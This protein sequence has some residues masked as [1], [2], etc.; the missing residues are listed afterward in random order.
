[1]MRNSGFLVLSTLLASLSGQT[2][3]AEDAAPIDIRSTGYLMIDG[4]YVRETEDNDLR[5]WE[6]EPFGTFVGGLRLYAQPS[7]KFSMT[8]NPELKSMNVFPIRPGIQQGEAVQKTKYDIYLEEAKGTWRFGDPV[9]PRAMLDFG[10]IIYVDNP[11]TKVL[12]NYLFRSMV[13]PGILFTKMDNTAAY[14]FG[15]HGGLDFL[16]GR[17]KNHAFLLSEVQH[18]PFFDLSLG[19][20]GSYAFGNFM[21]IGAGFKAN[22]LVPIRPSRTTPENFAYADNTYKTVP[23]QTGTV[24]T[25]DK[26]RPF[27]VINIVPR[28]TDSAQVTILDSAGATTDSTVLRRTGN[29]IAGIATTGPIGDKIM[30]TMTQSGRFGELYPELNGTNLRYSFSGLLV[31]GRIS[32]NPMAVFGEVNPLGRDALKIY[33]EAAVLGWKNYPGFYENRSERTPIMLGV[34][35]PTFNFVDYVSVEL[36]QYKSKELP[37]YD[38]RSFNNVPQPGNHKGEVETRW[39]ADRRAKD[40]LKWILAAKK[41]FRGW[42]LAAQVGTDHTKLVDNTDQALFDIMSRPSQWYAEVRFIA[43]VH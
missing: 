15:L 34:N 19:Y 42:G 18:F 33:A 37:T 1:M 40:D 32:L 22:S 28:G 13:Y 7:P 3:A 4:G 36:E 16:D 43:G 27:K 25:N 41:S 39:D 17:L 30:E 12:G 10:Y 23:F 21:E 20:S 5:T 11:E 31:G 26:G 6:H 29:G 38:N 8:V 2:S 35:L 14:L 24:I 9:Q